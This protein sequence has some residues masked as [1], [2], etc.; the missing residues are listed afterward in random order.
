MGKR[1]GIRGS[2][3]FDIVNY[4]ML[5]LF[6]LCILYPLYYMLI[7]SIS[8]GAAVQSGK[9]G[10]LPIGVNLKAYELIFQDSS[11]LRA[12]ANTILYTTVGTLVN[13]ALTILCA[14]PLSR[15]GFY[16]R[17]VLM[18]VIAVT[19]FFGGGLIPL[20]LVVLSLGL[21]NSMWAIIL[22]SAVSAWNMII[23]RTFFQGIPDSL[24]DAAHIDGAN[25]PQ[26]LW[27]VVLPT[28]TTILA[29]ITMFYAVGHWNSF[30]SALIFLNEKKK[31]PVQIILRNIVI[32]GDMR[33]QSALMMDDG[34]FAMVVGQNVKYAV[35]MV[36][37]APILAI[38]PFVQKYF[39]KGVMIG[40]LKE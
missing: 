37:I 39:I 7:I 30:F 38:Y 34:P 6:M 13:M 35:T 31:F 29:T 36:V 5:G 25:D 15:K 10:L 32:A 26:I 1:R 11:I 23:M 28:S 20:Y 21:L 33:D 12:Y 19:M 14:Y 8:D 18:L 40:S 9:V 3:A 27:R 24:F 16:G 17:N 22:P 4:A 2:V